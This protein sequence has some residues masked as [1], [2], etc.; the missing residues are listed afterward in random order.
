[1]TK[2]I[3]VIGGGHGCSVVLSGL[4][5]YDFDL[6]GVISMADDGGSTG[7]L[8]AQMGVPAVGDIRQCLARLCED[9]EQAELFSYRFPSGDLE[10]HSLGNL[11]LAAGYLMTG[12]LYRGIDIARDA[13]GVST[14]LI[15]ATDSNPYL[16][17]EQ[18]GKIIRGVHEIATKEI[19]NKPN[20]KL[21]PNSKISD[22]AASTI[23]ES[24]LIVIAPGHFYC[25]IMPALL[26]DG[27]IESIKSSD[28]R[29]VFICNLTSSSLQNKNFGVLDYISEIERLLGSDFIDFA[30]FNTGRIPSERLKENESQV[31]VEFDQS[32]ISNYKFIGEDILDGEEAQPN[33]NDKI[34]DIRSRFRHDKVKVAKILNEIL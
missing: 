14:H 5:S 34:A 31:P 10:G 26:V 21:T 29:V 15:P 13:L 17:L 19:D 2:K 8:R 28:A 27:M 24:D 12:S 20:L 23:N 11:F 30:L 16:L 9:S 6:A 18:E 33:P 3:T 25:S 7:R 1:M 4:S 22:L 32:Q